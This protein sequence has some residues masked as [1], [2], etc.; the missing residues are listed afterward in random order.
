MWEQ[1]RSQEIGW[2]YQEAGGG[3]THPVLPCPLPISCSRVSAPPSLSLK[4]PLAGFSAFS[5]NHSCWFSFWNTDWKLLFLAEKSMVTFLDLGIK[6]KVST[7]ELGR[8]SVHSLLILFHFSVLQPKSLV[9]F[10][11]NKRGTWVVQLK[12]R[13]LLTLGFWVWAPCGCGGYLK[14]K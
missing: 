14:M 4:F 13:R 9:H 6:Y 11:V 1:K 5:F 2:W 10:Q 12:S 7:S 8:F 3:P